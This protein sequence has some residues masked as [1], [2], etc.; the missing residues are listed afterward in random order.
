MSDIS[1]L[2]NQESA[3]APV[4]GDA[5][6]RHR[7]G[8]VSFVRRSPRMNESQHHA[9]D[10]YGDEY[11]I[12]VPH[13]H[14]STSVKSGTRIDWTQ[15]FGRQ[16][17]LIAEIGSGVGDSLVAMAGSRPDHNVIAFEVYL[18][19]IASTIGKLARAGVHNVR[20]VP[21]DGTEG[22]AE[23]IEPASLT[24]LW[25]FFPDP[26]PKKRH[27]KR[28]L[29]QAEFAALVAQRLAVG[30]IWRLATDWAEYGEQMREV[31]DA[32]PHLTNVYADAVDGWAIRPD[33]PVTRFEK[34]G[35][36]AGRQIHDLAYRRLPDTDR[37][38][39]D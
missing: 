29:V 35:L 10:A 14:L 19:A 16:A 3:E 2:P 36:H 12:E 4:R 27:H 33:R 21:A 11:L 39:H 6:A 9:M 37:P 25:T 30:G 13:D 15:A 34:R 8:I 7:R 22:L 23:L 17:P 1:S 24:E 28:R 5:V 26:W 18:P 20:L 31:L 32:E 38:D